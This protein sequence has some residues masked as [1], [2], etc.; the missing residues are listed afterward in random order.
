MEIVCWCG[1]SPTLWKL[2]HKRRIDRADPTVLGK[3]ELGVWKPLEG[4]E[5]NN[6]MICVF[7]RSYGHCLENGCFGVSRGRHSEQEQAIC[8][9]SGNTQ[10]RR[11]G[12]GKGSG[13]GSDSGCGFSCFADRIYKLGLLWVI[14]QR[15]QGYDLDLE[16]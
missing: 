6:V 10:T 1:D 2:G 16:L 4:V 5:Q 7:K 15:Q 8:K 14:R 11:G 9:V 3:L 12:M 13:D